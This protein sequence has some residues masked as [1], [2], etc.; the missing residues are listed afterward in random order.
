MSGRASDSTS[1]ASQRLPSIRLAHPYHR[2][3]AKLDWDAFCRE[4]VPGIL[5]EWGAADAATAVGED[6]LV[7]ARSCADSG[8]QA[9]D[10]LRVP[11]TEEVYGYQPRSVP[12]HLRA[13]V[14]VVVRCGLLEDAHAL[15]LVEPGELRRSRLWRLCRLLSGSTTTTRRPALTLQGPSMA[16]IVGGRERGQRSRRWVGSVL[17][18]DG[19]RTLRLMLPPRGL[20]NDAEVVPT[21]MGRHGH[22]VLSGLDPRFDEGLANAL[23]ASGTGHV[24]RIAGF[25]RLSR[26]LDKLFRI[27][28]VVLSRGGEILTTN[29]LIRNGEVFSRRGGFVQPNSA[30]PAAGMTDTRGLSGTHRRTMEQVRARLVEALPVLG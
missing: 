3:V 12:I 2:V 8:V 18:A 25:S 7:R 17:M 9:R 27:V 16:S 5:T 24:L 21:R 26:N 6:L 1:C 13:D 30:N 19:R 22:V 10:V 23:C 28:D 20:P 15:G 14:C 4:F 29:H 11:F